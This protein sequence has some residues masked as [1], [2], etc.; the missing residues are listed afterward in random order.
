MT[1][2]VK[3]DERTI[4]QYF[5]AVGNLRSLESRMIPNPTQGF[6]ASYLARGFYVDRSL[7]GSSFGS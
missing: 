1:S 7:F 5:G 2:V 3:C 4:M 6:L